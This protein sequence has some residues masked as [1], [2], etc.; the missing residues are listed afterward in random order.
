LNRVEEKVDSHPGIK[1]E[2]LIQIMQQQYGIENASI[3]FLFRG[4]GGDCYEAEIHTGERFFLK[5]HDRNTGF[6]LAAS[7]RAFYLPL[8]YQLFNRGILTNIPHPIPTLKG[9][10]SVPASSGELVITNFIEGKVVGFGVLPEPVLAELARMV[11]VLHRNKPQLKF[12]QPFI[13]RFEILS[14]RDFSTLFDD[15]EAITPADREGQRKLLDVLSPQKTTILSAWEQLNELK[16]FVRNLNNSMVICH[17]DLHGANLIMDDQ[18]TLYILDWENA[19]IAPLEHDMIFFAGES[20][21]WEVFWPQYTRQFGEARLN[22]E[23]LRFYYFRRSL[24]DVLG[25]AL[26]ILKGDGCE[27][28]D[29]SDLGYLVDC[30]DGLSSIDKTIKE[31]REGGK[32]IGINLV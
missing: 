15:L 6:D 11:G 5:L 20:N 18:S 29:Q 22:C 25:L 2:T 30:L 4:W 21:F 3:R 28:R 12:K 32:Q 24:E 8:M 23:I 13:E 9:E 27:D 7:S 17:T 31:I 14:R 1:I 16:L 19:M 26:R 10:L